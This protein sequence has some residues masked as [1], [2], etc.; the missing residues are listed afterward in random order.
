MATILPLGSAESGNFQIG[1]AELRFGPM[2]L[3]GALTQDNSV[4]LTE[5]TSVKVDQQ[6]QELKAGLPKQLVDSVI[7]ETTVNVTANAY[8]YTRKNIKV[9]LNEGAEATSPATI[10]A[11]G[12][13]TGG[14]ASVTL[15]MY[16]ASAITAGSSVTTGF[17]LSQ[18]TLLGITLS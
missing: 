6:R 18:G 17:G 14:T 16:A 4:G 9:M 10:V 7:T 3:A 13:G 1:N 5:S 11:Q 12:V 2:S 15:T 8:E